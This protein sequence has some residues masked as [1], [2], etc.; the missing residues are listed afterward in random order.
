VQAAKLAM[1]SFLM[2]SHALLPATSL[3]HAAAAAADLEMQ[4]ACGRGGSMASF[5]MLSHALLA[6]AVAAV[7]TSKPMDAIA[8]TSGPLHKSRAVAVAAFA[9]A[10]AART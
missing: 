9:C 8:L 2:L 1:A 7:R 6:A 10:T 4:G 5:V 3:H